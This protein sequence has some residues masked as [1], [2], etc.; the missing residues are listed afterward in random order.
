MNYLLDN[1]VSITKTSSNI[2]E[3]YNY[4]LAKAFTGKLVSQLTNDEPA[5][6]LLNIIKE[7][8]EELIISR[9]LRLRNIPI[10]AQIEN[11]KYSIPNKWCWY[12]LC[13]IVF[14]QEGPGIRKWQFTNEGV[15]LL[16]VGNILKNGELDFE[17]TDKYVSKDEFNEKYKHFEIQEGDLLFASSGGSWGK[18]AWFKN[19]GYKVMLN[20][21]TIRLCFYSNI[22]EP[23]YLEYFINSLFFKKQ[24]ELQLVG[25]QP[26]FGMTHLSK[27][28]IPVAPLKEQ[29]YIV[30]RVNE[31]QS[32]IKSFSHNT[33]Q[34][35]EIRKSTAI[36]MLNSLATSSDDD[37]LKKNWNL[38]Q[39]NFERVFDSVDSVQELK[40][41]ILQLAVQGKLVPQD[42][43]D[44][45]ASE[46]L[47]RI[48]AE[49]E[50]LITDKIIKKEKPFPDIT[51]DEIPYELPQ[52]WEWCRFG[53]VMTFYN[54]FAFS[55][56]DF[57]DTGVGVVRI[58]D[59]SN[60]T[61]TETTM[62]FVSDEI[63]QG[64][65]N[66]FH[67]KSGDLLIAMSGATTGKIAFNLTEN[68]Y[69]L[70]QRVGRIKSYIIDKMYI[71][72]YLSLK[73]EENLRK[74]KGSAIPNLSTKQINEIMFPLPPLT[75][76]KRI[77]DKVD[78]LMSLCDQ[79]ETQI[80]ESKENA[81]MLMQSVLQEAFAA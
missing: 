52:G 37:S 60:G 10:D 17:K 63:V 45:P 28:N 42:S 79:L 81:D 23:K 35:I 24:M 8:K 78:E 39:N 53:D 49:K 6:R 59:M 34:N 80:K 70:N 51:D 31:L 71:S 69:L 57:L 13:D 1:F 3:L 76:Q 72:Y 47:K 77:V 44:E 67:V 20:T 56:S 62:K 46:L 18:C 43:N 12:R 48:K 2:E 15:K 73:V 30:K 68:T 19:P 32:L 36:S 55:S 54:G 7:K 50:Q 26:N 64:V 27:I 29:K 41:T 25:M 74:S 9:K 22:F 33:S 21:S 40:K 38:V 58:G 14:F 16:N 5:D 4:V 66:C 75:E 11:L 61:I 65:D